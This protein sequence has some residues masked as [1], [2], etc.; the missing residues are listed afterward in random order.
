MIFFRSVRL[1]IAFFLPHQID[2]P[3]EQIGAVLRPRRAFRVI[4]HRK[5]AVGL[6][7]RSLHRVIQQVDMGC[8][9]ACADK[10]LF[11]HGVAVILAGDFNFIS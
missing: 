4:L 9:K 2:E 10:T 1:G 6:A 11:V 7:P 3:V 8:G 5:T